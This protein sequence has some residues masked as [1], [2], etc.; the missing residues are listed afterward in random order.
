MT[1]DEKRGIVYV[2]TGSAAS[3]FYGADRLGN[4]LFANCLLALD[5][6]TGALRWHY[7]F[8]HH[9]LFDR[10]LPTPPVLITFQKDGRKVDALAQ[11]TKQGF[12]FVLDRDT[13]QPLIP[14]EEQPVPASDVPGEQAHLTQPLPLRPAPYAR[15]RLDADS[16]T[17]RTPE[18]ARWA[19]EQLGTL[20]QGGPFTPMSIGVDT[21]IYPGLDG[22][23]E[24]GGP[25]YDPE[26][27]LLYI[28]ANNMA[29]LGSL[30]RNDV[31]QTAK[32]IYLRECAVCHRDDRRG[33][34]PQFPSLVDAGQRI[35]P[36]R[37]EQLVRRGAGRMPGFP[38]L[39]DEALAALKDFVL[40]DRDAKVNAVDNSSTVQ[41]YR[42]TGYRRFVDPEGYPAVGTP[43]GTL[44][45]LDLHRGEYVWQMPFGEFPELVERGLTNTGSENYGGPLV[46]AGGLLFIG[47]TIHDRKFRAFDKRTGELLWQAA[48]P[49]S[50]DATPITYKYRGRQYVVIFASGGKERGGSPGAV[51]VAYALPENAKKK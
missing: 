5:A 21:L 13:G 11:V 1:L 7:Q 27:R 6:R 48:L 31:G 40:H 51:Y 19:R 37:F 32:S 30:A 3:D 35:T 26:T 12:V 15:Q 24:W 46:T 36:E 47:A 25:A 43:W 38:R 49:Y 20:R 28:N 39:Q 42:F 16:M 10:D 29:W 9:D 50:A 14:V 23:A 33:S 44:N 45:A 18:A 41:P 2:P 22:G 4:N 8:V 34:P 17:T